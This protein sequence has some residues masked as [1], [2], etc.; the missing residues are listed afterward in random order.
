MKTCLITGSSKGLGEALAL[1]FVGNGYNV[2]IHGRDKSRIWKLASK[3]KQSSIH[4]YIIIGDLRKTTTIDNLE[5]II[6]EDNVDI[7]IN[8][9]G[10]YLNEQFQDMST[11]EIK[12]IIEVNLIAPILLTRRIYPIFKTKKS[13]LIININS[14][15]G[16][17]PNEMETVYCASKYG[18]RGFSQS[19]QEEADKDNVRIISVY[20]GAMQTEM[21]KDRK[22][23]DKLMR[24]EDVADMIF[25]LTRDYQTSRITEVYISRKKG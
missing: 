15:A 6:K 22:D 1:N 21:T 7:L 10:I 5:R 8:N 20:L 14:M 9:A 19:F 25:N 4:Y 2:I 17:I 23:Y 18:L 24:P 16:K 12:E 11:S 13:G 3:I